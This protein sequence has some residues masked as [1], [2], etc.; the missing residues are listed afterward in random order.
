M[1]Q[2]PGA[3]EIS[4]HQTMAS[5]LKALE[6]S[7]YLPQRVMST[8]LTWRIGRYHQV[9]A[10]SQITHLSAW[11]WYRLY[12]V[13]PY[14]CEVVIYHTGR[15]SDKPWSSPRS[16][17]DDFMDRGG[18]MYPIIIDYFSNTLFLFYIP[19]TNV[20]FVT[21]DL[22][23]LPSKKCPGGLHWQHATFE[24]WGMVHLHR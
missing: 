18:K 12:K 11:H 19:S 22:S 23:C 9:S 3:W 15:A 4:W 14:L 6:L 17:A 24:I 10:H 2:N 16:L 7:F 21:G 20:Y 8:A 5:S 13:V 1:A